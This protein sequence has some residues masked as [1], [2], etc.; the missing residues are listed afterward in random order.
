MPFSTLHFREDPGLLARVVPGRLHH[1]EL[2][3]PVPQLVL[4]DARDVD[5]P[6]PRAAV[7][8]DLRLRHVFAEDGRPMHKSWGNCDRVRRGG[9]PDGRR[10]HALDV[11]QGA[12]R[13]EH[14]VRLARRRR[15]A[16]RAAHPLER[17][18]V[19]R[20]LRP[21]G[22]L[23]SGRGR[24]AGRGAPDPRSLDPVPGGRDRGRRRGP[25]ARRRRA[26]GRLGRCPPISTACR[27]GTCACRA[28]ASRAPTT[29]P[30]RT[31][32]SRRSTRRSWRRRGCSRRSCRSSPT[33][34]TGTSSRPSVPTRP[35][36]ST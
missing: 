8:D 14:P 1:R 5:G 32:R 20:D 26:S 31:P 3:G 21:A 35:T 30:T 28:G 24:A 2:P 22:R 10:R 6:P 16:S 9:R 7:Q 19:L 29:R 36:A 23:E 17:L 15:G 13:G 11:R 4:L 18:R 25:P 12:A 27:P 34:S 33:R